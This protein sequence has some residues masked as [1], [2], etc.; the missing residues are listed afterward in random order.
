MQFPPIDLSGQ[1]AIVTGAGRGLGR[2]HALALARRGAKVVVS[3]L[4]PREGASSAEAVA[5]EIRQAGGE[6]MAVHASVMDEAQ[7]GAMVAEVMAQW[8]RVDILI[9]N[10]GF[11]RDKSFGKSTIEDFQAIVDVHLM[12]A[13]RC[14]KAVWDIMKAQ[15]R[16][17][18]V[19]TTSSSGLYGNFGQTNY[20][21]AKL[22]LVGLMQTLSIEGQ[23]NDIRVNCLAPTAATAM[24]EGLMPEEV[25]A[26]LKPEAVSPAVVY[27]CGPDAPNRQIVLAG[28]GSFATANVTMTHG[29]HL[30]LGD[31][32]ADQLNN[33]REELADRA[34]E[35]VPQ[36]G[37]EQGQQEVGMAMAAQR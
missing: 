33:C 34:G 12:G 36:A 17:R 35:K 30:G 2:C 7:V 27:L 25:L 16:G 31:D 29:L 9:N 20:G 23:K 11:L 14:T 24:T 28:A 6:A 26:A 18:I 19:F 4:A 10:A 15:N 32:V 22:A 5:Q 8:G 1:V 3:D 37:S 13:V 21:A